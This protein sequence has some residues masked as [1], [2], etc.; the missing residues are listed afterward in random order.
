MVVKGYLASYLYDGGTRSG[1]SFAGRVWP[2]LA[3]STRCIARTNSSHVSLPSLSMS[4]KFLNVGKESI[5]VNVCK[6]GLNS[7]R[8][9]TQIMHIFIVNVKH[10]CNEG[11]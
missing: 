6:S 4:A 1:G 11:M 5:P 10:H 7:V 8:K 2:P 9:G 3:R